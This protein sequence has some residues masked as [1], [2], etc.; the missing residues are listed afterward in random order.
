MHVLDL[1]TDR[2]QQDVINKTPKGYNNLSD[3][4]RVVNA[5]N[6]LAEEIGVT[7]QPINFVIGEILTQSK[8]QVIINNINILREAWYVSRETP[9]TPLPLA[10]NYEKQNNIEKILHSLDEFVQS[11]K[12]DKIYSGT[13]KAGGQIKFRGA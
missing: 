4:E 6:Y 3:L 10:W 13:F 8:M 9:P 5:I 7:V 2:T 12:I 1:I 11:V